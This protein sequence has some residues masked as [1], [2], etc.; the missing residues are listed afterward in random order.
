MA[1]WFLR[2]AAATC[3]T[4]TLGALV[5]A[6]R[7]YYQSAADEAAISAARQHVEQL[8]G[9]FSIDNHGGNYVIALHGPVITD[10]ELEKLVECLQPLPTGPTQQTRHYHRRFAFNLAN[11]SI[12]NQGVQAISTLPLTWLNLSDTQITDPALDHLRKQNR[13]NLVLIA[14]T[15]VTKP[16]IEGLH[17]DLP[18]LW[19]PASDTGRQRRR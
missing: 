2:F 7:H 14:G 15:K 18:H 1:I 9:S 16:A 12:G 13:L 17:A 8:G 4:I 19:I 6:G 10:S 5:L 3:L 11:T